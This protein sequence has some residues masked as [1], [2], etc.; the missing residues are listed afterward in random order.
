MYKLIVAVNT[1]DY[2]DTK[3]YQAA[4][5]FHTLEEAA[6]EGYQYYLSGVNYLIVNTDTGDIVDY[7]LDYEGYIY[8][9]GVEFWKW[10]KD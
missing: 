5:E 10:R 7:S 9:R 1:S 4:P 8:S 2:I 3:R 6:D